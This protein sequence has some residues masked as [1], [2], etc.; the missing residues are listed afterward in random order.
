M[1][2]FCTYCSEDKDK[3]TVELPAIERYRS[4]RINSVYSAALAVGLKFFIL[5]GEFGLIAPCTP[6]P[7]YNHLLEPSEVDEHSGKVASQLQEL[8]IKEIVYFT[9][10]VVD[11]ARLVSYLDSL[12]SACNRGSVPLF[13]VVLG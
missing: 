6:I 7:Y 9:K 10:P 1:K 2:M 11:D 5:S 13:V 8:G 4:K 12:K 3:S